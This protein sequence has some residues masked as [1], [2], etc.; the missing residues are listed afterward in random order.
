MLGL[1]WST[2]LRSKK[3]LDRWKEVLIYILDP[4]DRAGVR[5]SPIGVQ[6][7]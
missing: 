1:F 6:N 5:R 2:A 4:I 3:K 7:Y